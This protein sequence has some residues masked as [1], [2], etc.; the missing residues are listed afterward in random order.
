MKSMFWLGLF[1]IIGMG[2]LGISHATPGDAAAIL[3]VAAADI[4]QATTV[5]ATG[6]VKQIEPE[7]GRVKISHDAIPALGWSKMT[8]T[9]RVKDKTVL[10]GIAAGDAVRF[11]LGKDTAGQVITRMEKAAK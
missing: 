5:S 2:A 10:K 1:G 6:V 3:Q 7:Q 8:M 9:F 4:A 11:E